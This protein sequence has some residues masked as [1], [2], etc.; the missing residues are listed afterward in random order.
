MIL[1]IRIQ[2]RVL[3]KVTLT[4]QELSHLTLLIPQRDADITATRRREPH[5]LLKHGFWRQKCRQNFKILI[6]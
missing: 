6:G 1:R 4:L 2:E 5:D 3:V